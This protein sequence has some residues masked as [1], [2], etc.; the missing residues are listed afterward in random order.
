MGRG[1]KRVP[2][3]PR[4][5]F[6]R[7]TF[8]KWMKQHVHL[9]SFYGTSEQAVMNQVYMALLAF[10]LLVL[11]KLESRVDHSLLQIQ[12]WLKVLLWKSADQWILRIH[13]RPK[14]TSKGRQRR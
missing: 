7:Q 4:Q 10:C 1:W 2:E 9:Q 13:Y 11:M 12:R 6:T 8:F 3:T 5:P 14:R